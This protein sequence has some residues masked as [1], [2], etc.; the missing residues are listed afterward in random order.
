MVVARPSAASRT[1]W[2]SGPLTRYCTGRPAGGP[3][4]SRLTWMSVPTNCSRATCF[5]RARTR[6]RALRSLV[7]MMIWPML[8]LAT[9]TSK[10]STKRIAPW[11]T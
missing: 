8:G 1:F 3:S 10:A 7:T 5:S 11:P 4:G 2:M 6:S 9:S